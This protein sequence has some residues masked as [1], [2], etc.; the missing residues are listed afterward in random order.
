MVKSF[1]YLFASGMPLLPANQLGENVGL[2]QSVRSDH[3]HASMVAISKLAGKVVTADDVKVAAA[4]ILEMAKSHGPISEDDKVLLVPMMDS[5]VTVFEGQLGKEHTADQSAWDTEKEKQELCHT[6]ASAKF[7]EGGQVYF[8][9]QEFEKGM[10]KLKACHGVDKAWGDYG[11][12]RVCESPLSTISF[13]RG[14]VHEGDF[15]KA[16]AVLMSA[17]TTYHSALP[18]SAELPNDCAADQAR[19]EAQ[20]CL[21]RKYKIWSCD[22]QDE[23]VNAV[24]LSAMK[25]VLKSQQDDRRSA[26]LSIKKTICQVRDLLGLPLQSG[27]CESIVL[28][29]SD[30][31]LDLVM[32]T[33]DHC[34]SNQHPDVLVYPSQTDEAQCSQWRTQSY[35]NWGSN[36]TTPSDCQSTCID[37]PVA[38][39]PTPPIHTA[40]PTAAPTAAPTVTPTAAPTAAPTT[41]APT[42]A[43]T[44]AHLGTP[45]QSCTQICTANGGTCDSVKTQAMTDQDMNDIATAA[46]VPCGGYAAS[47]DFWHPAMHPGSKTCIPARKTTCDS[48][49]NHL[50]RF[51][52]C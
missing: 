24:G 17:V 31:A 6:T 14:S 50:R 9:N 51:C 4:G 18:S 46:G 21:H 52:Y 44:L 20:M 11:A 49:H 34:K 3:T 2:L 36:F 23:C 10:A 38:P 32:P 13:G 16:H 5:L 22:A 8:E 47:A 15:I 30:L 12:A 43:S 27:A 40:P 45:G 7:L 1:V 42:A 33:P 37:A 39:T 41:A 48:S 29:A 19:V 28:G 25:V 26:L 35:A